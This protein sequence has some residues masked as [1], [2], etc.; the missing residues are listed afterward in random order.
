MLRKIVKRVVI[1][2]VLGTSLLI[3]FFVFIINMM[4]NRPQLID[5]RALDDRDFTEFSAKNENG[6]KIHACFYKGAPDQGVVILCHGHGV[7][8]GHMNDMVAFLRQAG[9]GLIVFDFR[10]H[11]NSEGKLCTIGLH[12]WKDIKAVIAEAKRKGFI[13]ETTALAGYGRSMG[14]ASLINGS[15]QLPEIKAFILESSFERLRNIAARDAKHNLNL[16]DTI[17]TD[18][19][20]KIIDKVTSAAYSQNNPVENIAGIGS[21]PALLIHDDLDHR[22]DEDAFKSLKAALPSALSYVAKDSR[23]VQAHKV[24][25]EEFEKI[26]LDFL[27]D[28]GVL[29]KDLN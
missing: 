1:L 9:L 10:A 8:H 27:V 7:T 14:A 11:G 24:H 19:A 21:R 12:E 28:A 6:H 18:I 16:P 22:A 29:K 4:I 23:H 13:D 25:P 20:F 3:I 15:S 2:L 17:I 5:P 26:F